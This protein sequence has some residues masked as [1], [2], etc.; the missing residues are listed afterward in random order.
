MNAETIDVRVDSLQPHPLSLEIYGDEPDSVFV[1]NV[2]AR[3]IIEP[4]IVTA[5]NQILAGQRP[6]QLAQGNSRGADKWWI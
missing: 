2:R 5:E 3:G 6:R 1:T 4:L